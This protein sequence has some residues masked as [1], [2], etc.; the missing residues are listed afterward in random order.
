MRSSLFSI[1]ALLSLPTL[2]LAQNYTPQGYMPQGYGSPAP[3]AAPS[4]GY[5]LSPTASPYYQDT[6]AGFN[7]PYSYGAVGS[8]INSSLL[9]YGLLEGYYQY[10]SFENDAL[11][12]AHGLGLALSAELFKPFYVR[13]AFSWGSGSSD[14]LSK[15]YDLSTVQLG[16]GAYFAV[17]NRFHITG[18]VGGL[19]TSLNT[20]KS[21]LSFTDGAIYVKPGVRFAPTD[22]LELNAGLTF[23]S[24]D[25]YNTRIVDLNAFYRL[26]TQM[27]V[28]LGA[29]I[30]DA[31]TGYRAGVRF[32]W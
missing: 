29:G 21:S 27:D 14:K 11:D 25:D 32:R 23:T 26:F 2:G 18:E 20:S 28:G 5:G 8:D 7:N 24:A 17:A 6:S 12:P 9:S 1:L 10:T 13:G 4:A 19:Y 3:A 16:A 30:G 15:N 31:Q 22:S